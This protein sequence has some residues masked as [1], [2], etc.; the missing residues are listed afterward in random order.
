MSEGVYKQ[1][2]LYVIASRL[3]YDKKAGIT[4]MVIPAFYI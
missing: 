3:Y 2:I 4:V 1:F